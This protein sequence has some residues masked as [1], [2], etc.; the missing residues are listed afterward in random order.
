MKDNESHRWLHPPLQMQMADKHGRYSILLINDDIFSIS[1]NILI[2][3]VLF[4]ND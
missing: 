2:N 3:F 4:K 1:I